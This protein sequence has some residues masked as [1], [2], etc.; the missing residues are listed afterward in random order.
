MSS[1]AIRR[2]GSTCRPPDGPVTTPAFP[3]K[4]ASGA[5][6]GVAGGPEITGSGDTNRT[7]LEPRGEG[8]L[9]GPRPVGRPATPIG[10]PGERSGARP[11][12]SGGLGMQGAA[13]S[14]D[15]PPGGKGGA[16]ASQPMPSRPHRRTVEECRR[17]DILAVQRVYGTPPDDAEENGWLVTTRSGYRLRLKVA[18]TPGTT[19]GWR[20]WLRCPRCGGRRRTLFRPPSAKAHACRQCLGLLYRSQYQPRGRDHGQA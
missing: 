11:R 19:G 1:E 4:P 5:R 7:H 9:F 6:I 18:S 8:R 17:L 16:P 3:L 14:P 12:P 20:W 2:S 15:R 13:P 10:G